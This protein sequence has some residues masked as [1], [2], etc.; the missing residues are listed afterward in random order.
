MRS[1]EIIVTEGLFGQGTSPQTSLGHMILG[2]NMPDVS[3]S[4][5]DMATG[6]IYFRSSFQ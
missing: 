5:D 1:C 6:L 3:C 4:E 2:T